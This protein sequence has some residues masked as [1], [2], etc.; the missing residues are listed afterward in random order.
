MTTIFDQVVDS[1]PAFL[2][3]Q[4]QIMPSMHINSMWRGHERTLY[5]VFL[6]I[7]E[8]SRRFKEP[9]QQKI[10]F[11]LEFSLTIVANLCRFDLMIRD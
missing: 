5:P 11:S 9:A 4:I 1:W 8:D 10:E 6:S 3:W 2:V 7:Q